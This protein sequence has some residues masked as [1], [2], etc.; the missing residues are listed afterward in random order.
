M[1]KAVLGSP[2]V[3]SKW[4]AFRAAEGEVGMARG[5][6]LPKLD[7][8]TGIGRETLRQPAADDLKYRRDGYT[9]TLSQMVYDG[10]SSIGDV[11]RL[12]KA[13]LATYFELLDAAENTAL[14][15][16]RAYFDVMR[17]R[18]MLK[19]AEQNYVEHR[20]VY[21]QLLL[22]TQSGAGRRVDLEHAES[23]LALADINLSTEQ[24]NLHDVTARYMRIINEMP[25]AIMFGPGQLGKG[26]PASV[27]EAL[28]L[29]FQHNPTLRTTVENAEAAQY[30]LEARRGA[31]HPRID[32]RVRSDSTNNY[33]GVPGTREQQVAE[34]ILNYNIFNGGADS[35]RMRH[36]AERRSL[37]L[38]LRE[39]ACRDIRQTLVIAYNDVRRL[40]SQLGFLGIQVSSAEKTRDAYRA[41]FNIG[42]RSLLDLLDTENELLTARR[43]EVNAEIDLGL[44][45]LRTQAGMGRLL[46]AFGLKH[47]EHDGLP[48]EAEYSS[49]PIADI[50][51]AQAPSMIEIDNNALTAKALKQLT[52]IKPGP[53][54]A[55]PPAPTFEAAAEATAS[56]SPSAPA[57][58]TDPSG[59]PTADAVLRQQLAAWS[60]AWSARDVPA[61]LH[62]YGASFVPEGG[63]ARDVWAKQRQ[64][65]IVKPSRI[66]VD[67]SDVQVVIAGD[68]ATTVFT[69]TYASDTYGDTSGKTL[70]WVR[71]GGRWLIRKESSAPLSPR[72]TDKRDGGG[73]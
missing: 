52:T 50:C 6:L 32:L 64:A 45:Y 29:A 12:G 35:A 14:E 41:Q 38:D 54:T 16:A 57:L 39:K 58:N 51:A 2:E 44:A 8:S 60:A 70:E 49:V 5:N 55:V 31:F 28:Q 30:D 36:Y 21:E 48:D 73:Q 19:L 9:V 63:I 17:Y 33:Q 67:L 10:F 24:A 65:R 27:T 23:R 34:L 59:A 3:Q 61:Y 53:R 13:K 66:Q 37:A 25:P 4:H 71:E 43:T 56:A 15:A 72:G 46:H 40:S 47:T 18:H 69:Q 7:I 22:R 1:Q 20:A 42:Q 11:R 62:F 68:S 26:Y